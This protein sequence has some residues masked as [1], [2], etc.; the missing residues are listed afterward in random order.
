M[1][2]GLQVVLVVEQPTGGQAQLLVWQTAVRT[3]QLPVP[4]Q[5]FQHHLEYAQRLKV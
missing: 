2:G 4:Q 1:V 3:P 5:I